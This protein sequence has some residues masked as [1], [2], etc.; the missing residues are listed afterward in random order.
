[1]KI[2]VTDRDSGVITRPASLHREH[3][4]RNG[5][6]PNSSPFAETI[7]LRIFPVRL[8]TKERRTWTE[9]R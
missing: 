3:I 5:S 8:N 4:F 6:E 2:G 7:G 9:T 1:M